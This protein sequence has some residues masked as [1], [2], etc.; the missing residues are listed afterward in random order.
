MIKDQDRKLEFRAGDAR[1]SRKVQERF[2]LNYVPAHLL[3]KKG[4]ETEFRHL[5]VGHTYNLPNNQR[6]LNQKTHVQNAAYISLGS[7]KTNSELKGFLELSE[8]KHSFHTICGVSQNSPQKVVVAVATVAEEQILYVA[9]RGSV[10][11]DDWMADINIKGVTKPNMA[12][13]F[14]A[15]FLKR[16]ETVSVDHLLQCADNYKCKTIITCGH[17]LGG[18]VSSIV[19]LDLLKKLKDGNDTTI[20]A[21]NI[22]FGAPS[23][24]NETVLN[25]CKETLMDKVILNYTNVQDI[26]PGL[27][28]LEHTTEVLKTAKIDF[29]GGFFYHTNGETWIL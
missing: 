2:G 25:M 6:I 8:T 14:H 10:T 20:K 26:V 16:S 15:G 27:L 1:D 5:K 11:K 17:S 7:Y 23:F 21:F 13:L 19:A 28:N 12:G 9:F 24:G 4:K 18:A 22:T 3:N 29:A